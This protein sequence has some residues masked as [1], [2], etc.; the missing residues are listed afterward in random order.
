MSIT[1]RAEDV[2]AVLWVRTRCSC[3]YYDEAPPK[4]WFRE[5]PVVQ[6]HPEVRRI[7]EK[8]GVFSDSIGED[9]KTYETLDQAISEAIERR[10]KSD[11]YNFYITLRLL[12][13]ASQVPPEKI[14]E[15][16]CTI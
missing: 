15:K 14:V 11:I 13:S 3:C 9:S 10:G 12:K 16:F 6:I 5:D 1:L 7:L 8:Y 4:R 2:L